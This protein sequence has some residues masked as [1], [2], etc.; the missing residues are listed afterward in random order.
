MLSMFEEIKGTGNL[1]RFSFT[2]F[3]G[4]ST[5]TIIVLLAGILERDSGYDARVKLGLD[6]L[7]RMAEGNM[8]AK[9]G[10]SFVGALQSIANEA[11]ERL[12]DIHSPTEA[13]QSSNAGQSSDYGTWLEWLSRANSLHSGIASP[14]GQSIPEQTSSTL[15][16][17]NAGPWALGNQIPGSLSWDGVT[18][19]QQMTPHSLMVPLP[20]NA[21]HHAGNLDPYLFSAPGPF[22]DD[23]VYL[24]GLT[25]MDV[26]NFVE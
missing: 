18:P 12:Q 13:T 23:Q 1:T 21:T 24:M 19:L 11:V 15:Q 9:M 4:C 20:D 5:A 25:G 16:P 14:S 3:Q 17:Q 2:D 6:C 10:V 22:D 7:H 26:L 8:T